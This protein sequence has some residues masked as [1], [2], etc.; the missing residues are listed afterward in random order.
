MIFGTKG[1][2]VG[3][4]YKKHYKPQNKK[5]GRTRNEWMKY[6]SIKDTK[7]RQFIKRQIINSRGAIC[8]ICGE[9]ITDMKDCTI[10]H[11]VPTSLGGLTTLDNCRL[12]HKE[13]NRK[14]GNKIDQES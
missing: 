9:L 1:V 12:A 10:D 6:E 14:R 3:K 8:E 13:C 7:Q 4:W 5:P 11:I 2:G